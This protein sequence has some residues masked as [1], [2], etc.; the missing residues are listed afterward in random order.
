MNILAQSNVNLHV[1]V[2]ELEMSLITIF[3]YSIQW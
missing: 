2:Y 3:L 1:I